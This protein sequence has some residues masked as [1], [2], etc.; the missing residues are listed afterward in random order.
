M[1]QAVPWAALVE[2]IARYYPEGKIGSPLPSQRDQLQSGIE[3]G[4]AGGKD[5]VVVTHV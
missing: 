5:L 2:L 3:S 4:D 1:D